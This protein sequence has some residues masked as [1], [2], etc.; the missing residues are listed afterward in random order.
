MSTRL[1]RSA[2]LI[3]AATLTSR[4]LGVAREIVLAALFG[5]GHQMDGFH[6]AFR[7]P[8]LLRREG[9]RCQPRMDWRDSGVR[10][11]LTQ[12]APG[13]RALAAVQVKVFINTTL[14]K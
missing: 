12:M 5:A 11:V 4:V 1:V 7:I 2:G 6:V 10:E 3:G 8:T 9:W 13:T 14:S